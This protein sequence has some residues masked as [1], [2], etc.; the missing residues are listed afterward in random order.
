MPR[1][2]SKTDPTFGLIS[3]GADEVAVWIDREGR[4]LIVGNREF[5]LSQLSPEP[6]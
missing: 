3:I 2:I 4:K 6:A 1:A 5:E